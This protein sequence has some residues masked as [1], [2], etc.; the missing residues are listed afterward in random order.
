MFIIISYTRLDGRAYFCMNLIPWINQL[1]YVCM[2]VRTYVRACVRACVR[3]YVRTYIC[4]YV[5]MYVCMSLVLPRNAIMLQ[6]L[7]I[8]LLFYLSSGHLR[9]VNHKRQFQT[10]GPKSGDDQ[11]LVRTG[12][13]Q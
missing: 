9:E 8:P 5:C 10:F 3:A 4:M 2:Y 12:C 7:I 13:L 1:M 6:H 11:S